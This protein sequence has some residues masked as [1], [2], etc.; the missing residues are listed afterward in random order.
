MA[1]QKEQ[2]GKL[3]HNPDGLYHLIGEVNESQVF[4]DDVECIALIDSGAKISTITIYFA[5]KLGLEIKKLQRF[6]SIEGVGE[7]RFLILGMLR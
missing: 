6:I 3:Y 4:I 2:E 1:W 5:Q 7:E